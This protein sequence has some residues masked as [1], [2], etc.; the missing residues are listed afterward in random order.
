ME[1]SKDILELVGILGDA[2]A[3]DSK[4]ELIGIIGEKYRDL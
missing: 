1:V 2:E 4:S 3:D